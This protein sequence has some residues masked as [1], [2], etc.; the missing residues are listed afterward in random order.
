MKSPCADCDWHL[1]G[2]DKNDARC[3]E[4]HKRINYT[5]S[6][7]PERI[8]QFAGASWPVSLGKG[9]DRYD[10]PEIGI[11]W[12]Q[13]V[14]E[15]TEFAE[16]WCRRKALDFGNVCDTSNKY[17]QWVCA[18]WKLVKTLREQYPNALMKHIG[19]ALG[20]RGQTVSYMLKKIDKKGL[21]V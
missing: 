1:Q 9:S 12:M 7:D 14:N 17:H 16:D 8:A 3:L 21:T 19:A 13:L 4:C 2:G 6:I 5:K 20:I 15:M 10:L 11:D 18:R